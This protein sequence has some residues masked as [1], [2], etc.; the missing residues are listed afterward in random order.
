MEALSILTVKDYSELP[1]KSNRK[2]GGKRGEKVC[3]G[4]DT[5]TEKKFR[6][7]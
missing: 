5:K 7:S 2:V 6:M 4:N 1:D 3:R